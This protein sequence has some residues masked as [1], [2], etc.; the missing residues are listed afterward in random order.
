M[1]KFVLSAFICLAFA[2]P[3]SAQCCDC[4]PAGPQKRL[5][6]VPVKRCLPQIS[7]KSTT[8]DCGCCRRRLSVDRVE[9]TGARLGM[10]DR[11]PSNGGLLRGMLGRLRSAGG[12]DC[13]CG[14][15]A[16]A[17]C[18]CEVAPEPVADCG[19]GGGEAVEAPVYESVVEPAASDCGCNG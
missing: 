11:E 12:G 6:F 7:L 13:G 4:A 1:F 17:P 2:L 10:V 15:P 3:A 5:G 19:C 8:D 9:V 16:P 18:G 14:A